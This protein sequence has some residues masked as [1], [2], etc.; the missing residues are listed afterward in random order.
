MDG[1]EVRR[2]AERILPELPELLD[3]ATAA[4]VAEEVRAALA[5]G[6]TFAITTVLS[7]Y[8]AT[9][10]WMR[11]RLPDSNAARAYQPLAGLDPH[12]WAE[13]YACPACGYEWFRPTGDDEIP[14]CDQGHEP[15]RLRAA[16]G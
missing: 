14:L 8:D 4:Q 10:V 6:D 7:R 15:V 11:E 1:E 2:L 5:D 12:R 13:R 16:G 9:R 3:T